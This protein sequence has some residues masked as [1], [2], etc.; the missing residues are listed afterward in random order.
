MN[1][2]VSLCLLAWILCIPIATSQEQPPP[3]SRTPY[4]RA[5]GAADRLDVA[6][7][8]NALP[9]VD[10]KDYVFMA[11]AI[12][13]RREL[14]SEQIEIF[15]LL[16]DAGYDGALSSP[17]YPPISCLAAKMSTAKV[18]EAVVTRLPVTM[19][20]RDWSRGESCLK[21]AIAFN[22]VDAVRVLLDH[23]MSATEPCATLV[24]TYQRE[25]IKDPPTGPRL[26]QYPLH[27]AAYEGRTEMLRLLV[28]RGAWVN[29][30]DWDGESPLHCAALMPENAA[31]MRELLRMGA[32]PGL[33][34]KRGETPL[35]IAL[36][37]GHATNANVL[38]QTD[39][40]WLQDAR[41]AEGYRG[42]GGG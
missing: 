24:G 34:T 3:R 25:R 38:R 22:S 27:L 21:F 6:A 41:K 14:E 39:K 15:N 5:S 31:T 11:H 26:G 29:F 23:G 4:D 18:L 35:D 20:Q 28:E 32:D 16:V 8:Q 36:R 2:S 1:G 10:P 7:F 40:W 17:T 12:S 30:Q 37:K 42:Q 9:D 13:L 19:T 33:K